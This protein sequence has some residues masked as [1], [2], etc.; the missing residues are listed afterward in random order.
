MKM[1]AK[2]STLQLSWALILTIL[3]S[4]NAAA[5]AADSPQTILEQTADQ[6]FQ[7]LKNN[8]DSY[9]DNPALVYEL[10]DTV[11]VPHIDFVRSAKWVLGRRYWTQ[12]TPEQRGQFI[13]EFR[14]LMI[15]FYSA[16]LVE[17]LR[18][19]EITDNMIVFLPYTG[20][21]GEDDVTVR[22]EVRRGGGPAVP[23]HYQLRLTPEGWKVYD[24]MVDGVSMIAT[25]RTSFADTI[26]E[27]GI[28]GLIKTLADR[29]AELLAGAPTTEA[30]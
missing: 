25:Y 15:R 29:N 23:V 11:L 14:T 4:A 18:D 9:K 5:T 20:K 22:S 26:R 17:Y 2:T 8:R 6:M 10:V 24:L 30:H 12:A 1:L 21:P 7:S 16:A 27:Q 19:H 13:H 28:D 3:F